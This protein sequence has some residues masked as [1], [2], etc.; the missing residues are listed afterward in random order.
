[1]YI[2]LDDSILEI[3]PLIE[4]ILSAKISASNWLYLRMEYLLSHDLAQY[5]GVIF[6][7]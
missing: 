3:L 5:N 4:M 1:M 7:D 2:L 6:I